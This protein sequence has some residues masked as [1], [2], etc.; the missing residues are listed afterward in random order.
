VLGRPNLEAVPYAKVQR[1]LFAGNRCT[2]VEYIKDGQLQSVKAMEEVIVC[3]GAVDSPKLL[4]LSGIGPAAELRK[5]GIPVVADLPGVGQ[6]LH[7]HM[8]VSVVYEA[9]RPIPAPQMNMSEC[10][11]FWRSDPRLPGPD[12]QII[13]VHAPF[14]SNLFSAPANSYTIAAGYLRPLS[15]GYLK[16]ANAKPDTPPIINPNYLVE[17]ADM[18]GLIY[19]LEMSRELGHARAFEAWRKA[20]VVPGPAVKSKADLRDF[21]A[22][23]ASSYS[24]PVGTCKMGIDNMSVVDPELQVYGVEGLRVADASIQPSIV[25]AGPNASCIMIGEKVSASIKFKQPIQL[26]DFRVAPQEAEFVLS[27]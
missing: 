7:D 15:R 23:A 24:H 16:L 17:D 20:E 14:H 11:M 4:L 5:L 9:S 12:I 13:F 6:N 3:A 18:R 25:S 26:P 8:L 19:S 21:M 27:Y 1:L 2:G 22:K 10:S